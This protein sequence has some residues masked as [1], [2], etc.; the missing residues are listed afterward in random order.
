MIPAYTHPRIK[1]PIAACDEYHNHGQLAREAQAAL[2]RRIETYPALIAAEKL[3]A[4]KADN[5][6]AAWRAIAADWQ[7]IASGDGRELDFTHVGL[8]ARIAALDTAIARFF[9]NWDRQRGGRNIAMAQQ[10]H[11]QISAY[12]CMR[13]HAECEWNTGTHPLATARAAARINREWQRETALQMDK[14]A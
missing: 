11:H 14:V 13:A 2:Q 4:T 5:D 1:G 3:D 9:H 8:N 6:I 12:I 7:W 10:E